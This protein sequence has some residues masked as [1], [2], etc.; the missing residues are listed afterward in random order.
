MAR[1]S[2]YVLPVAGWGGKGKRRSDQGRDFQGSPGQPVVAIGKAH[3]VLINRNSQGFGNYL[4]YQ[5]DDGPAK[6]QRIY[7]GH[8]QVANLRIGQPLKRGE[9]V[10]TLVSPSLGNASKLS[11]WTEIGLAGTDNMPLLH[12]KGHTG[13]GELMDKLLAGAAHAKMPNDVPVSGQAP[14]ADAQT[15]AQMDPAQQLTYA[16][17]HPAN[18]QISLPAGPQLQP[19]LGSQTPG[20]NQVRESW[21]QIVGQS[22]LAPE[23]ISLY[24]KMTQ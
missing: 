14:M 16:Q 1:K 12:G 9:R 5:L 21:R 7:V 24:S 2:P 6:G 23:T 4:V 13:G 17:E 15:Q 10:A 18:Q 8:A 22:N 11:G 3:V 19:D 20:F